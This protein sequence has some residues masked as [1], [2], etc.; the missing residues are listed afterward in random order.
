MNTIISTYEYKELLI[1]HVKRNLYIGMYSMIG[2]AILEGAILFP[3]L[4]MTGV[5][6][7]QS[8]R[9]FFL[10]IPALFLLVAL[11]LYIIARRVEHREI[12]HYSLPHYEN[13]ES[14][15]T[16]VPLYRLTQN[17]KNQETV[18]IILELYADH[19]HLYDIR[20]KKVK[21][22]LDTYKTN[23][24]FKFYYKT[25]SDEDI[26]KE[27]IDLMASDRKYRIYGFKSVNSKLISFLQAEGY[28]IEIIKKEKGPV[29]K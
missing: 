6:E 14:E 25:K 18:Y 5:F 7:S 12:T 23:T 10:L 29:K 26:I 27:K 22:F 28:R 17:G 1:K 16:K 15:G 3:T 4:S 19:V 11:I 24:V 13:F 21:K 20:R 8:A 9:T 2:V